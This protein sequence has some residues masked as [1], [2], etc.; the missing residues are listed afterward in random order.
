M[1]VVLFDQKD[2]VES[3]FR[4]RPEAY[5][6]PIPDGRPS[7]G[8]MHL[9]LMLT[10]GGEGRGFGC[11]ANR[12]SVATTE[13]RLQSPLIS[14]PDQIDCPHVIATGSSDPTAE[15]TYAHLACLTSRMQEA[16]SP[17]SLSVILTKIRD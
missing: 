3:G 5:D 13:D 11:W 10:L 17:S 1:A 14:G 7:P 2:D 4:H 12:G 15:P 6:R 8:V 16:I 9:S